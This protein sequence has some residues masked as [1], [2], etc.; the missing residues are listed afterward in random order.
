M[1]YTRFFPLTVGLAAGFR[2]RRAEKPAAPSSQ[3]G[4]M[5]LMRFLGIHCADGDETTPTV[6]QTTQQEGNPLTPTKKGA[7][8]QQDAVKEDDQ[9]K[10]CN[11]QDDATQP[12]PSLE[13][14]MEGGDSCYVLL[15]KSMFNP[16]EDFAG[17]GSYDFLLEQI[18]YV[19]REIQLWSPG[20]KKAGIPPGSKFNKQQNRKTARNNLLEFEKTLKKLQAA[21]EKYVPLDDYEV[22]VQAGEKEVK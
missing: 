15:D 17:C 20:D 21:K 12:V 10:C 6:V 3:N 11:P 16:D 8:D 14:A 5:G 4:F 2:L 18:K 1:L 22:V 19:E 9:T 7:E 13:D